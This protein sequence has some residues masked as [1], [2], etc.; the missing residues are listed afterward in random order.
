MK[1]EVSFS[2]S[3]ID[4][5]GKKLRVGWRSEYRKNSLSSRNGRRK[6]LRETSM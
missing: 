5:D 4:V 2:V 6:V 3:D 1:T